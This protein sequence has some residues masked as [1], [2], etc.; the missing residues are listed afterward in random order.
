[1]VGRMGRRTGIR[2]VA[3]ESVL[4]AAGGRAILLQLAHPSVARGVA[5]HSDFVGAPLRRLTGTLDYIYLVV[6]GSAT[7]RAAAARYVEKAHT[8]VR[9]TPENG[10]PGY[11]A[12][13]ADLQ[14]WVAATLYDSA[15]AMQERVLPPI[16]EADAERVYREYAVLGTALGMPAELWPAN[17]AAFAAWWN[18]RLAALEVS[19]DARRVAR[20]L[21][22]PRGP[23]API[24]LR[25]VMPL[26][27][28]LT[29]GLLDDRMRSGFGLPWSPRRQRL[30]DAVL[31][32]TR[33]VWPLLP[34]RVR[35]APAIRSLRRFR[36]RD[37]R[38]PENRH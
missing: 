27:R 5:E 32:L 1:M 31:M 23:G 25:I 10:S 2:A 21:L 13:D 12:G 26:A 11:S 34:A 7:E 3:A 33:L 19:D 9:G 18:E 4:V 30:L 22:H 36:A 28:L 35:H 6:Y 8:P 14:L 16:P 15:M 38:H 20:D 24:W 37:T 17:R 29:T